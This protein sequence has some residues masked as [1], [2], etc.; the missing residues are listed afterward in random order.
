MLSVLFR[1]SSLLPL[2]GSIVAGSAWF[3]CDAPSA[4]S[5]VLTQVTSASRNGCWP[6]DEGLPSDW[7][8]TVSSKC[9][10]GDEDHYEPERDACVEGYLSWLRMM[11]NEFGDATTPVNQR[12]F[13][14]AIRDS[15]SGE[16]VEQVAGLYD[17]EGTALA[18]LLYSVPTPDG[19]VSAHD[20]RIHHLPLPDPNVYAENYDISFE[21]REYVV[22]NLDEMFDLIG[23]DAACDESYMSEDSLSWALTQLEL[24]MKTHCG[25]FSAN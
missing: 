5:D 19:K 3:G 23:G 12:I 20:L 17:G 13:I 16:V 25:P 15:E 4:H 7:Q 2:V 9:R 8:D 22:D 14:A 10:E 11:R 6:I 21:P 1:N 24:S 18:W